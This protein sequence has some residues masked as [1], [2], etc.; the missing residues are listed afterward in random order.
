MVKDNNNA[1]CFCLL[2]NILL[3]CTTVRKTSSLNK[4]EKAI[5]W[6]YNNM[7]VQ[8]KH[9]NETE[10]SATSTHCSIDVYKLLYLIQRPVASISVSPIF[11]PLL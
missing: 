6:L 1:T 7:E 2:E 11:R 8:S 9:R 5:I 4:L 3:Y 10:D